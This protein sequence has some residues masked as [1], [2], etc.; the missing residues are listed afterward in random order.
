MEVDA[1]ST[2]SK[3]TIASSDAVI[4]KSEPSAAKADIAN[5]SS[6]LDHGS[7]SEHGDVVNGAD[8]KRQDT[9]STESGNGQSDKEEKP[10]VSERPPAAETLAQTPTRG[11]ASAVKPSHAKANG[12][13][14]C[15]EDLG[16]VENETSLLGTPFVIHSIAGLSMSPSTLHASP[17]LPEVSPRAGQRRDSGAFRTPMSERTANEDSCLDFTA[18]EGSPG[19]TGRGR[20]GTSAQRAMHH[21]VGI[22]PR[23][24]P[25]LPIPFPSS[26]TPH[27]FPSPSHL[28]PDLLSPP[29]LHQSALL[30]PILTP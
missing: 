1:N 27:S 16:A 13:H 30:T 23:P 20:Q 6:A 26:L 24:P 25:L 4:D 3:T 22:S 9:P 5:A 8:E 11:G 2:A 29:T 28:T 18:D 19:E 21:T 14:G 12:E 15:A 10:V 17:A 7:A